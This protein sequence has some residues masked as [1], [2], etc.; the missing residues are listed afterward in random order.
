MG[1]LDV[2]DLDILCSALRPT[3]MGGSR[4]ADAGWDGTLRL[5][6]AHDLLPALWSAGR[7]H[8][9]WAA[10]PP[11][12]L[13]QVVARFAPGTTQ[14]PLVLQQAHDANRRRVADLSDQGQVILEHLASAG[15]VAVPLKGLHVLMAGWWPDPADRVMRDLDILVSKDD[16]G[17]ASQ[18]LAGLGYLP[19]TTGHTAAAD[20][21]LPAVALPGR[22]GSVELHT[23]LVVSRW[24]VVLPAA[25]ILD[26][27]VRRSTG[28]GCAHRSVRFR[29][30]RRWTRTCARRAPSLAHRSLLRLVCSGPW[31]M[32]GSAVPCWAVRGWHRCMNEPLFFPVAS[33]RS[34]CMRSTAPGVRG[35]CDRDMSPTPFTAWPDHDAPT[36]DRR[37]APSIAYIVRRAKRQE[38]GPMP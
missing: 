27:G 8:D 24:S 10:L 15:I 36:P 32:T 12:A 28:R 19:F 18:C 21:E 35:S 23:A 4:P 26:L 14:P 33:R 3:L 25:E 7:A 16:A 11:D 1:D 20:H 30:K 29:P 2:N 37:N 38:G 13:A 9:W 5:A 22:A 31:R 6:A 34:A 17:R